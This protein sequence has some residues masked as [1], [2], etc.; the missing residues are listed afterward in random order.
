MYR[1]C[2]G[3]IVSDD[4]CG[5]IPHYACDDPCHNESSQSDHLVYKGAPLVHTGIEN[6]DTLTVALQ[7]IEEQIGN[8]LSTTTTST[9]STTTTSTSSSTTTT[10]TTILD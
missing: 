2:G 10:T 3:Y 1:Y 5:C 4:N 8:L 9:S 7:K 6:C